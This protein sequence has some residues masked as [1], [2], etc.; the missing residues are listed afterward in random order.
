MQTSDAQTC[1]VRI[2]DSWR[3]MSLDEAASQH[4]MAVKRCPACHGRVMINGA[5][6]GPSCSS[7]YSI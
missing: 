6:S 1:E 3:A 7:W 5:Y 2:G 4:A